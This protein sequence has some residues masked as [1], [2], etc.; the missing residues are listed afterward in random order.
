MT[1]WMILLLVF[2]ILFLIGCIPIGATISYYEEI[3]RVQAKIGP[4]SIGILPAKEKKSNKRKKR[5]KTE[6]EAPKPEKKKGG[7]PF[8]AGTLVEL[9]GL[10]CRTLGD[11]RRKIRVNTLR[12]HVRY[13]G[14]DDP[15]KAAIDYGRSW[16]LIG[17]LTPYLERLFVIKKRDIQPILD[18]NT[19]KMKIDAHL[20]L[21]ITV[22]RVLTLALRAGVGFLKIMNE[23]KK[24][25]Q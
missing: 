6:K 5:K 10:L 19:D 16:A 20:T 25:V 14:G 21:T 11:L 3:L 9:L 12:L 22:G 2:G 15:A 24:A 4:F 13:G 7:L 8:G 17:A 23:R 18:Y 1:W